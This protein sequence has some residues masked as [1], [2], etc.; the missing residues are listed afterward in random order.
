MTAMLFLLKQ[1]AILL[2]VARHKLLQHLR[3]QLVGSG[4]TDDRS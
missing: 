3:R 4:G 2:D 1:L